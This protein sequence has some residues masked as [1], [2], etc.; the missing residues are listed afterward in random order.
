[1]IAL[2]QSNTYREFISD[3]NYALEE[4]LAKRLMQ[5]DLI[6]ED[7]KTV[8]LEVALGI[9]GQGNHNIEYL[10]KRLD[11]IFELAI[12]Q[13]E[14]IVRKLRRTAWALSYAGNIE[15]ISRA[16]ANRCRVELTQDTLK[17]IESDLTLSGAELHDEIKLGFSKL[18]RRILDAVQSAIVMGDDQDQF[19]TRIERAFP[20]SV[21]A[22]RPRR[23][24]KPQRKDL[25][26]AEKILDDPGIIYDFTL[27]RNAELSYTTGVIDDNIW[28]TMVK[29]Y[30]AEFIPTTRGVTTK[31]KYKGTKKF[32]WDIERMVTEDFVKQVRSGAYEGA[33]KNGYTDFVWIAVIDDRTCNTKTCSCVW[34]DGLTTKEIEKQLK[35]SRKKEQCRAITPPAHIK[36]RCDLS[37]VTDELP[38][39]PIKHLG[40]FETWLT[41][42]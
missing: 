22:T 4:I 7:V 9:V 39:K 36:C 40:S 27:K 13:T 12:E 41:Q 8:V 18:K 24:R 33:N 38:E 20:K 32:L 35:T 37:P 29:D 11:P 31:Y 15:A 16:T 2:T 26:E 30:L 17:D 23:I 14:D 21:P 19:K 6:V 1:M 42:K 34:R 28:R 25:K 5:I 3:L 10:D